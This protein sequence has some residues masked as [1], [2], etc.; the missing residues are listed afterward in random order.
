MH[1]SL[2]ARSLV[3]LAAAFRHGTLDVATEPRNRVVHVRDVLALEAE[4]GEV[5]HAEGR[6]VVR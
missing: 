6:G 5:R 3:T 1:L 2:S 4:A